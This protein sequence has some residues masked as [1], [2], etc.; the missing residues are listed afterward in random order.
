VLVDDVVEPSDL[1]SLAERILNAAAKPFDLA[2]KRGHI[3][4]SLGIA[5]YPP[6]GDDIESLVKAADSAMYDAKQGGRNAYRFFS[7]MTHQEVC[8]VS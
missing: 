4:A 1:K 3:S 2:G 8:P 7:S 6:D 5:V